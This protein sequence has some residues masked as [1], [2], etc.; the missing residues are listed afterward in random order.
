VHEKKG[1]ALGNTHT[2]LTTLRSPSQYIR[3]CTAGSLG[4]PPPWPA[5]AKEPRPRTG[6]AMRHKALPG[7]AAGAMPDRPQ[8]ST[9][10]AIQP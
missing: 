6:W 4:P 10:H 5:H 1:Y 2:L 3:D 8:P 7:A 9:R